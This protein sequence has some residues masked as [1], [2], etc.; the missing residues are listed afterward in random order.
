MKIFVLLV[1][2]A[3]CGHEAMASAAQLFRCEV[4]GGI[5]TLVT[6]EI[7]GHVRLQ[8]NALDIEYSGDAV[9]ANYLDKTGEKGRFFVSIVDNSGY[10]LLQ[11]ETDGHFGYSSV[12]IGDVYMKNAMSYCWY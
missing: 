11:I 1:S 10:E 2:L 12:A 3:F 5:P 4:Y 7:G 9:R 6:G 8:T